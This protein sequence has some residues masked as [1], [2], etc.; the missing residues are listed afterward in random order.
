MNV[1]NAKEEPRHWKS[2]TER[3]APKRANVRRDKDDPNVATSKTAK[4]EPSRGK[5]T[6]DNVEP[7]R[8]MLRK[9]MDAPKQLQSSTAREDPN[10]EKLRRDIDEPRCVNSITDN[11][12][13]EPKRAMPSTDSEE[14]K[15]A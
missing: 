10:R 14:P 13:T 5:P 3:E 11:E 4:E 7:Q 15:R 1:R 9:D 6:S 8:N 12:K 2:N